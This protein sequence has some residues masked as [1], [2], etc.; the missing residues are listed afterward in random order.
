MQKF[1]F[2]A[3]CVASLAFV[4]HSFSPVPAPAQEGPPL[5]Y[6]MEN[7]SG[8]PGSAQVIVIDNFLQVRVQ[9]ALPDTLYTVWVDYR[10][11]ATGELAADYP[12]EDGAL[13]RG[14][15]PALSTVSPVYSGMIK[16]KNSFT[17][18]S[19]GAATFTVSLDYDLL[20][21]GEGPVVFGE[22][23]MQGPNR[24]GGQ[25]MR[26]YDPG[27][28]GASV[29]LVDDNGRPLLR[30]ATPQGL[31]IVGH[32]DNLTHGMTPGVG[33]VDHFS[34]YKGDFPN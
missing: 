11:R 5:I 25:W 20:A 3:A 33:G 16:D 1:F 10:N 22:L 2:S 29:Q 30:R 9:G 23:G 26:M 28:R 18:N 7:S 27:A 19:V 12:D 24:V 13:E 17:T 31:T 21:D 34:A 4:A 32:F 6:T 15:A 8:H 14:V